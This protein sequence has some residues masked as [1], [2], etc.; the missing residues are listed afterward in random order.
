MNEFKFYPGRKPSSLLGKFEDGSSLARACLSNIV[1]EDPPCP[2]R[3]VPEGPDWRFSGAP[4][5]LSWNCCCSDTDLFTSSHMRASSSLALIRLSAF[6][7]FADSLAHSGDPNIGIW[8]TR[9]NARDFSMWR[10]GLPVPFLD[11]LAVWEKMHHTLLKIIPNSVLVFIGISTLAM[12]A[13][14][15]GSFVSMPSN[16]KVTRENSLGN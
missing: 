3:R 7:C 5:S 2:P 14:R 4:T 8:S 6:T 15:A 9:C 1:A 12:A 16:K 13:L 11:C 10:L